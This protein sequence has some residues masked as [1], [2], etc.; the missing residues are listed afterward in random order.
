M[1]GIETSGW[2]HALPRRQLVHCVV[3]GETVV[4]LRSMLYKA[5]AILRTVAGGG[6][7]EATFQEVVFSLLPMWSHRHLSQIF[8]EGVIHGIESQRSTVKKSRLARKFTTFSSS[9]SISVVLLWSSS[10]PLKISCFS[11]SFMSSW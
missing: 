9:Q 1:C 2:V 5:T 10:A 7:D 6:A 3:E 11:F 8:S 4:T